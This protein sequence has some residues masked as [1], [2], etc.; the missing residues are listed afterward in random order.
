V[1]RAERWRVVVVESAGRVAALAG[2]R[3]EHDFRVTAATRRVVKIH[4]KSL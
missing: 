4:L 2:H 3:I 1:V